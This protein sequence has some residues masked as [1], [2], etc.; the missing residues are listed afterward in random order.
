MLLLEINKLV[1]LC[2]Q[3]QAVTKI[4]LQN[5]VFLKVKGRVGHSGKHLRNFHT[6]FFIRLASSPF[7]FK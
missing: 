1:P 7:F 4:P 3:L 6:S 2:H 5:Q